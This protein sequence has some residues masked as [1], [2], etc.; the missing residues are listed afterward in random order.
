MCVCGLSA[1]IKGCEEC[2]MSAELV[3]ILRAFRRYEVSVL[4][5]LAECEEMV[6]EVGLRRNRAV[7]RQMAG[8]RGNLREARLELVRIL[9][10]EVRR[11]L[12]ACGGGAVGAVGA[13]EEIG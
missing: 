8:L 6:N 13:V 4:T 10:A 1:D 9:C 12:E 11:L 5:Q 2:D 7:Q 3:S